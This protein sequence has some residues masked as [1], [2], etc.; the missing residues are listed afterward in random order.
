VIGTGGLVVLLI[1]TVAVVAL[2]R[3]A[4]GLLILSRKQLHVQSFWCRVTGETSTR[5]SR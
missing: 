3:V 2:V 1:M 4:A 5:S